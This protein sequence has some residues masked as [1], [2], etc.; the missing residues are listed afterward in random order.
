MKT[1]HQHYLNLRDWAKGMNEAQGALA[2]WL[3]SPAAEAI[4][5]VG[6]THGSMDDSDHDIYACLKEAEAKFAENGW[7][8]LGCAIRWI[9]SCY[10]EQTPK[11]YGFSSWR[12]ILYE[13][14]IFETRRDRPECEPAV[15]WYRGK[16]D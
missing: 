13:S 11:R 10:P 8:H 15:V 3:Q 12:Q 2:F 4:F 9:A 6:S 16:S 5:D 7:T 1:I 14:K